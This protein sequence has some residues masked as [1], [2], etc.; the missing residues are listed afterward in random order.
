MKKHIQLYRRVGKHVS[1]V[2]LLGS[3]PLESPDNLMKI[4]VIVE[5]AEAGNLQQVRDKFGL[6]PMETIKTIM[7]KILI[8]LAHIHS[9]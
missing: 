6:M 7:R 9:K 4:M 1:V 5:N 8:G 2:S 3:Q